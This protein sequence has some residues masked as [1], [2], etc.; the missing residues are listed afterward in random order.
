MESSLEAKIC[1]EGSEEEEVG[2]TKEPCPGD[3]LKFSLD[4]PNAE[5][6]KIIFD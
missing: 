6:K 5:S 3:L 2:W 1:I 4:V